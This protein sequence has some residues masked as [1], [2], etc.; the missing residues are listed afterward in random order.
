[1]WIERDI[2]VFLAEIKALPVKVLKGPRQ[3]GKTSVLEKLGGYRSIYFDDLSVR[4]R[5]RE[6]PKHFLQQLPGPLILDEATLVPEIFLEL[7]RRVDHERRIAERS[8]DIW[9][10]GSNQTLLQ[11]SVQESLA[12]R[13]SYFDFNTLSLHEL[14]KTPLAEYF[15]KGGWPE[16]YVTP[17]L[18]QVRYLNDLVSTF[19][20]RD[21][22]SAAGIE[23]KGA[24]IRCLQL[25]AGRV[26]QL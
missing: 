18:S 21:I 13:A 10:T 15:M 14:P 11:R 17:G 20:E 25:I 23:R 8:L 4:E 1:M 5:A 9:V 16:L 19:I 6:N 2:Q 3:V 12:G 7:K 26:G 24:F 22:V